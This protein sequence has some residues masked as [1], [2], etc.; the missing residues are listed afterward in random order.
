M[1]VIL[2]VLFTIILGITVEHFMNR[3]KE[4]NAASPQS[5]NSLSLSKIM[6]LLPRGVFLQ[7]TLTWSKM[8][9]NG[10]ILLGI[11]PVLMGLIGEPDAVEIVPESKKLKKGEPLLEIHKD[12]KVL[13]VKTPLAGTITAVNQRF[14]G[15]SWD[16][17]GG[18][19]LYTIKP[20]KISSEISNWFIADKSSTWLQEK[21]QLITNFFMQNLPQKKL[22]LTMTDG[23]E[24]PVGVLSQFD[25]KTWQDFENTFC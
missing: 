14:E 6:N 23:G 2:F 7:P 16:N 22:G 18:T 12:S 5:V 3:G 20:E 13:R 24:L 8:L 19:W 4:R 11:H 17:M 10:N 21:F 1:T 15:T 9:D 25:Q